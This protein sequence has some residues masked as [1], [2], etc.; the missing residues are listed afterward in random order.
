MTDSTSTLC[1]DLLQVVEQNL[2]V[3]VKV[4]QNSGASIILANFV[5]KPFNFKLIKNPSAAKTSGQ[6]QQ[7]NDAFGCEE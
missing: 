6:V 3:H 4:L 5:S 1:S 2:D 7:G